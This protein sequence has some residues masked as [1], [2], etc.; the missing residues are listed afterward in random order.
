[1]A[2][3]NALGMSGPVEIREEPT[4]LRCR[5]CR[6][7]LIDSTSLLSIMNSGQ[8]A[9]MC[10]VWHVNVDS[11]PDWILTAVDQVHWTA[12]KLNCQYCGA[13]L[14]G[15][16]FLNCSKCPCGHDTAVHLSKSRVD[17]DFRNSVHLAQPVRLRG[18]LD[19]LKSY[20]LEDQQREPMGADISED[21]SVD[22]PLVTSLHHTDEDLEVGSRQLPQT[23]ALILPGPSLLTSF[24]QACPTEAEERSG[25]RASPVRYTDPDSGEQRGSEM[26]GPPESVGEEERLEPPAGDL[27]RREDEPVDFLSHGTRASVESSV[28]LED[29][30]VRAVEESTFTSDQRPLTKRERNR[31]KSQRRK[32][33]KRERWIQRQLEESEEGVKW[34][35][36]CSE[37][38]EK[39]GYTCAV[40]LDVY[41]RPYMCNPCS[42]VFCEPC[43]RTLAK[44]RP[45]NTPCPLC[46]T[47][48]S[49]VLF[50]NELNQETRTYFPKEYLSRKQSYQ[51]IN[52]AKWPL[53]SCPKRFRI[54]WGYQRHDIPARRW[55]FA[56]TAFGFDNL[57]LL[58]MWGWPFESNLVIISIYSVHWLLASFV[59]CCFCYF[60][61][62]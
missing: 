53:P 36:T 33:R 59:F 30:A 41:F 21:F 20:E 37:D 38:E 27:Q 60:F 17:E 1:M 16:N 8:A 57:D 18:H 49:Q 26:P 23:E 48:I 51:S 22:S 42:H 40:C 32:Q 58:D 46:R 44:N 9:A 14:G 47:I 13:R 11:L 54:F 55:H 29:N 10:S 6:K 2:S 61:F 62:C 31:L 15:F 3:F 52:Y 25:G 28:E 24:S 56:H 35:M 50:Q 39:E 12:G 5:K 4:T 34:S 7:C 45:G 19:R 43:L